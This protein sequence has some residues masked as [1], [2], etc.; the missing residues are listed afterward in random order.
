MSATEDSWVVVDKT[1]GGSLRAKASHESLYLSDDSDGAKARVH[2]HGGKQSD[3]S[4]APELLDWINNAANESTSALSSTSNRAPSTSKASYRTNSSSAG[5][6]QRRTQRRSSI[7]ATTQVS[8]LDTDIDRFNEG[9]FVV[10]VVEVRQ[11]GAAKAMNL[12]CTAQINDERFVIPPVLTKPK[13]PSVW[14]SKMN[15]TFV[16]DVSRQFTFNLGVY[17]THPHQPRARGGSVLAS[18]VMPRRATGLRHSMINESTSSLASDSSTRT[19]AKIR[20]GLRKIFRN[21]NESL[22]AIAS[23]PA[24][25]GCA[26]AAGPAMPAL[27]EDST[28]VLDQ[29]MVDTAQATDALGRAVEI[30]QHHAID[31]V[32]MLQEEEAAHSEAR[33]RGGSFAEFAQHPAI[34]RLS[35]YLPRGR[36]STTT[37]AHEINYAGPRLRAF[38]NASTIS[39]TPQPLGELFLD[40]RV[41]RREKRRATFMLPVVNQDQVA[42]RGGAHV[43]MEVVLEYG[44]IVHETFEERAQRLRRERERT[45]AEMQQERQQR[46]E[47]QWAAID[48]QDKLPRLR[49]Y[50]SVFTRCG[51]VSTWKRY[52]AVLSCTRILFYDSEADEVR[53]ASPAA[54]VSLFHLHDA[55]IPESDLV[56]IGPGGLELRLSPLA[57]TDRHR[58]KSAFP[59]KSAVDTLDRAQQLQREALRHPLPGMAQLSLSEKKRADDMSLLLADDDDATLFKFS[60]WQCRVYL[61]LD[62]LKTRDQ[63]LQELKQNAVPSCEFARFRMRQ[64]R[65]WREHAFASATESLRQAGR[66]LDVVS[67][68]ARDTLSA[69]HNASA[70][71]VFVECI[72]QSK[73]VLLEQLPQPKKPFAFATPAANEEE[74]ELEGATLTSL[75]AVSASSASSSPSY[76]KQ[77]I[78]P[79]SNARKPVAMAFGKPATFDIVVAPS[80]QTK[81]QQQQKLES[82]AVP[83]AK[84]RMRAHRRSSSVGDLRRTTPGSTFTQSSSSS[85]ASSDEESGL[86]RRDSGASTVIEVVGEAKERRQGTVSRRFLFVWNINEI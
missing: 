22:S 53:K 54:K 48:E 16:F 81:Q 7:H 23:D 24:Y 67:A 43:E 58:R 5:D 55:G 62:S 61:L 21:K 69:A 80:N 11:I 73:P 46:M 1:S 66:S 2:I 44:I 31:Q 8:Q 4:V 3:G 78:T 56:S 25:A 40:M 47:Q 37:S 59:R 29:G 51:R 64:R 26:E 14:A 83:P 71:K 50:L 74:E 36:T 63:W 79:S 10:K 49:G 45:Q 41:E 82:V 70:K 32:P 33:S 19:T 68:Q 9:M 57:M 65:A 30:Q 77:K 35:S 52:W 38:S 72:S 39:S 60:D 86:S 34:S 15:D 84:K 20:R 85:S 12:Q 6:R 42:M 17:G 13:G 27:A 76:S 75:A 18:R 28:E